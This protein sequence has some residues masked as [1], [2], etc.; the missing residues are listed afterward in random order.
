MKMEARNTL[1]PGLLLIWAAAL[2]GVVMAAL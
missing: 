2:I 1:S